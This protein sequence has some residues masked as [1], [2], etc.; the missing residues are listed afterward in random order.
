VVTFVKKMSVRRGEKGRKKKFSGFPHTWYC[1]ENCSFR[2][3]PTRGGGGSHQGKEKGNRRTKATNQGAM[4]G[5]LK[6]E[7]ARQVNGLGGEWET[8]KFVVF[9]PSV[10]GILESREKK[11]GGERSRTSKKNKTKT[12]TKN[13]EEE[14]K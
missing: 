9:G 12:T 11:P 3:T 8:K 4:L 13:G 5:L 1:R 10:G 14:E 6:F 2:K 7:L